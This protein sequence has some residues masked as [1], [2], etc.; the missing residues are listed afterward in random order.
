MPASRGRS[1]GWRARTRSSRSATPRGS[2]SSPRTTSGPR[3]SLSSAELWGRKLRRSRQRAGAICIGRLV[4][5]DS[6]TMCCFVGALAIIGPRFVLAVWWLFGN[7]V[8]LAFDSWWL[9]LLG[10]IFLPWTTLAYVI[11]WQPGG[12]D[13]NWD[14]LLIVIGVALDVLTYMHRA[15]AKAVRPSSSY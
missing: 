3:R 14:A 10:L 6:P 8:E 2:S 11:A 7:K 9:P 15:A 13:G 1:R 12:L 5:R 4:E